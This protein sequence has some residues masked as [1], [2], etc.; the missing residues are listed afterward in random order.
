[1]AAGKFIYYNFRMANQTL[2]LSGND[3]MAEVFLNEGRIIRIY[4]NESSQKAKDIF[5]RIK[6]IGFRKLGIVD[7]TLIKDGKELRLEH[8]Q[9]PFSNPENWTTTQFLNACKFTLELNNQLLSHGLTLKDMIPENVLFKNSNPVFVDFAS[10][11]N[12][13][14]LENLNWLKEI[15][16]TTNARTY[17]IKFMFIKFMLIPLHIGILNNHLDMEIVLRERFCNSG[18]SAPKF[19]DINILKI[20]KAVHFK[21][22]FKFLW[23]LFVLKFIIDPEKLQSILINYLCW[24]ENTRPKEKSAYSMYY[25][26]KKEKFDIES[27]SSWGPKQKNFSKALDFFQPRDLLD[28]GANTGWFS[29]L[30]SS[31]G[32][33]VTSIE[34]DEPS[35]DTLYQNSRTEN[36]SITIWVATFQEII[37]TKNQILKES[38]KYRTLPSNR[39]DRDGVVAFGLVHHLCLGQGLSLSRIMDTLASITKSFLIVEYIDLIDDKIVSE[40]SFFPKIDD[41]SSNYSKQKLLDEG[42]KYFKF[43][44]EVESQPSTRSLII[45]SRDS[46]YL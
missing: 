36:L 15:R 40:K 19:V 46:S 39:F 4:N 11:V 28:I 3:D 25:D 21:I 20:R 9:I 7:T 33:D 45:F 27:D 44:T 16:N 14:D 13:K 24:L 17:V 42:K 22:Y 5:N 34:V 6:S 12:I 2:K 32:I 35:V 37:S 41:M 38:V 26:E 18:N 29:I 10:I 43:V 31:R 23:K 8:E 1:M 30:A